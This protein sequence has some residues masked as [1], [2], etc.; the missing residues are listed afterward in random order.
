MQLEVTME[1]EVISDIRVWLTIIS[2]GV[3]IGSL[4]YFFK[5][6]SDKITKLE[7]KIETS[8]KILS[9]EHS[10]HDENLIERLTNIVARLE[11]HISQEEVESAYQSESRKRIVEI[12]KMASKLL[13]RK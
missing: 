10:R 7:S 6:M 1:M 11:K 3:T 13:R 5:T 4:L 8:R 12:E 2:I 9:E